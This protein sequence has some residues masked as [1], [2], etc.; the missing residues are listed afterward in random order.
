MLLQRRPVGLGDGVGIE[1]AV[2]RVGRHRPRALRMP[3]S[4]TKCATW[5]P[6]GESSRAIDCARPR[7]A[8]LPMAKV[9]ESAKP[10]TPAVAPDSRIA[11]C[12]CGS[13]RLAA[14][15]ETRKAPKALISMA[16]LTSSGDRSTSGPLTRLLAL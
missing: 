5:M 15:W 12:L 8:N 6:L 13:I 7:S 14:C 9:A 11:P 10:F 3:P 2:G 4:I 16:R 1:Q